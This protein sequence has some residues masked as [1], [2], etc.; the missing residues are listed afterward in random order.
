MGC[1]LALVLPPLHA[2]L[3]SAFGIVAV[4]RASVALQLVELP[5]LLLWPWPTANPVGA[6]D[7]APA[8]SPK[9][10]DAYLLQG[11]V[12]EDGAQHEHVHEAAEHEQLARA[13]RATARATSGAQQVCRARPLELSSLLL[14]A[15]GQG[16]V[17]VHLGKYM[18][19]HFPASS[20][21][22]AASLHI[23]AFLVAEYLCVVLE[24]DV[25]RYLN[26]KQLRTVCKSRALTLTQE[27]IHLRLERGKPLHK[28]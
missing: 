14:V 21:A 18:Q 2:L 8:V 20:I 27:I 19:L 13:Q 16:L 10:S 4:L 23:V 7:T 1:V 9:L 5:F 15:L 28:S 11:I 25:A 12:T 6:A 24:T 3:Y 22:L 26:M 17:L